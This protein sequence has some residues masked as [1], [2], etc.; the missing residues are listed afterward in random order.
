MPPQLYL[1]LIVAGQSHTTRSTS[2]EIYKSNKPN[3]MNS[4]IIVKHYNLLLLIK[5]IYPRKEFYFNKVFIYFNWVY[6]KV[7]SLKYSTKFNLPSKLR[8]TFNSSVRHFVCLYV[9][10][11]ELRQGTLPNFMRFGIKV[12][13]IKLR[14][15][16]HFYFLTYTSL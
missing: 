13:C 15:C 2:L 4:Q 16:T 12:P 1:L 3:Y 11:T 9:Y 14:M 8:L 10:S 7:L 6:N 5:A